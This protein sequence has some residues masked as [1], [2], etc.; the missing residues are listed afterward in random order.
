MVWERNGTPVTLAAPG[1]TVTITDLTPVKFNVLLFQ[2]LVDTTS[3]QCNLRVGT[4]SIDLTTNYAFRRSRQGAA[5]TTDPNTSFIGVEP[6]TGIGTPSFE[7]SYIV[8]ISGQEKLAMVWSMNQNAAGANN[9]PAR[10]ETVGKW[11]TS[12]QIDQVQFVNTNTGDIG[13]SSNLSALGSD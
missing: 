4:G 11:V 12:T 9:H 5:D 7:F 10:Q 3:P 6:V 13:I 8:N 1:D 2:K